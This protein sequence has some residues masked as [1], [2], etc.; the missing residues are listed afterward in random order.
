MILTPLPPLSYS[1]PYYTYYYITFS[2][3]LFLIYFPFS[4]HNIFIINSNQKCYIIL[5]IIIPKVKK[6]EKKE[7]V[8]KVIV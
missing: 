4:T 6:E 3:H 2:N 7:D 8:C 5:M 1:H